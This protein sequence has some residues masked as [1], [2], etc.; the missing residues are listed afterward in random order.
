MKTRLIFAIP[1]GA[2]PSVAGPLTQNAIG[3]TNGI[4]TVTLDFGASVFT[5]PA[6]W[7]EVGVET[8]GGA[9]FT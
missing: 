6:R 4:F 7:L 9:T 8:N 3:V 1:W 5:G 2:P